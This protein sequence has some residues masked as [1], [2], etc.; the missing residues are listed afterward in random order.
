MT[1]PPLAFLPDLVEE[2]LDELGFLWGQRRTAVTSPKYLHRD[3]LKLEARIGAH[4]EGLLVPGEALVDFAR[5]GLEGDDADAAFASAFAL[6]AARVPGA[7]DLVWTSFETA[8]PARA[9]GL[10]EALSWGPSDA[11]LARL[12]GAS[13]AGAPHVSLAAATV[14]AVRRRVPPSSRVR[15]SWLASENAD[16]RR[17]AWKLAGS[18]GAAETR[19]LWERGLAD[20]DADVKREA[21]RAALW[22][23]QRWVLDGAR[24]A[25]LRGREVDADEVLLV[26]ATGDASDSPGV[27]AWATDGANGPSRFRPLGVLGHPAALEPLL[28]AMGGL[29]LLASA[30]AGEAFSKITGEDVDSGRRTVVPPAGKTAADEFELEFLDEMPLP[31]ERKAREA[32]EKRRTELAKGTRWC[33]GL[34]LSHGL[35]ESAHDALDQESLWEARLRG[36]LTGT[37]KGSPADLEAYPRVRR[38]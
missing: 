18:V 21:R 29:D 23:R 28:K 12:D 25:I 20:P 36:I 26:A 35:P 32:W 7:A 6:L 27:L 33:R 11:L 34:D 38:A 5:F 22:C 10:A 14:L 31:D 8:T 15:E 2:H 13:D 3:V 24:A 19:A 1:E 37:W 16:V 9:L 4:L 17:A 30:Y